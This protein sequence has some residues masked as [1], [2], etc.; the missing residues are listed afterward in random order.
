MKCD[1][2]SSAERNCHVLMKKPAERKIFF[3][4][5]YPGVEK[6]SMPYKLLRSIEEKVEKIPI[7][8]KL[9]YWSPSAK[10]FLWELNQP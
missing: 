4:E 3:T 10:V 2:C 5:Q 6:I 9:S 1:K 7:A 8:Y